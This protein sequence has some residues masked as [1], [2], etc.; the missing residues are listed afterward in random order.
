M[1]PDPSWLQRLR[2]R[3]DQPPARPRAPLELVAPGL[4]GACIGSIEPALAW[5]IAGEGLPL[6]KSGANWCLQPTDGDSIDAT[7]AA[8]SQWLRSNGLASR[9]RD[10][11][12]AVTDAQGTIFGAIERAAVRRRR[13]ID[14]FAYLRDVFTRLPSMTNWQI[15][16]L[17]PEAWAKTQPRTDHRAAA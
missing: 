8:V 14:P 15:K 2:A 7:L 5:R 13:G 11:R 16:D 1:K 6:F 3:L 12:L 9:W 10:E 17:T 4:V